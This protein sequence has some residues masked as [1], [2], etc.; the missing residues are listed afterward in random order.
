MRTRLVESVVVILIALSVL[1][2]LIGIPAVLSLVLPYGSFT[3]AD[4]VAILRITVIC[5]LGFGIA[6]A[7]GRTLI[8]DFGT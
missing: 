5:L 6:L 3:L 8:P 2:V 4:G 7:I 1:V